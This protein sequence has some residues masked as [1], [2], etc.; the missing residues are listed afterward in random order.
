MATPI[1]DFSTFPN[2]RYKN[3]DIQNVAVAIAGES[4]PNDLECIT[5]S[6]EQRDHLFYV[7]LKD[8]KE[9]LVK[10]YLSA[11]EREIIPRLY[12]SEIS[13][14]FGFN[15]HYFVEE[16]IRIPSIDSALENKSI[17]LDEVADLPLS[18][19]V[20]LLRAIQEKA[21]RPVGTQAE[22]PIDVR[23]LSAT[24]KDLKK[25]VDENAFRNDLF[26][27]IN[28]IELKVPSLRERSKDIPLLTENILHKLASECGMETPSL[29]EEATAALLAYPFPGNVRELENILERAF[30][31]CDG[32]SIQEEDLQLTNEYDIENEE[33]EVTSRAGMT[34][35]ADSISNADGANPNRSDGNAEFDSLEEYLEGIEK[36]AIIKALEQTHWNKTAAAKKLGISFRALRYRLQKLNLDP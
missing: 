20:K 2:L 29:S 21:V 10:P 23:I 24:H 7:R 16:G 22:I 19:Q 11:Q 34:S 13:G 17:F 33:L 26:Y 31:L 4:N 28:V 9:L 1:V 35:G 30:T 5:N 14:V 32:D 6:I 15:Q 25:L 36:E 27:R 18:M 12:N 8:K 3:S